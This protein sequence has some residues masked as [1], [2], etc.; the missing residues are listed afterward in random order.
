MAFTALLASLE[1]A[2]VVHSPP[3]EY[4]LYQDENMQVVTISQDNPKV[5]NVLKMLAK[6]S[7][8]VF[9]SSLSQHINDFLG[10]LTAYL[11]FSQSPEKLEPLI[12]AVAQL[13]IRMNEGTSTVRIADMT[14]LFH[15]IQMVTHEWKTLPSHILGWMIDCIMHFCLDSWKDV[16]WDIGTNHK[17]RLIESIVHN[18]IWDRSALVEVVICG[19]LVCQEHRKSI[20]KLVE[21]TRVTE[22]SIT[23]ILAFQKLS[24]VFFN[25]V[26][27]KV[28]DI[29]STLITLFH[30]LQNTPFDFYSDNQYSLRHSF[31]L[32]LCCDFLSTRVL[33][34]LVK[35]LLMLDGSLPTIDDLVLALLEEYDPIIRI[36]QRIFTA[37]LWVQFRT[38]VESLLAMLNET[39]QMH[40]G[41]IRDWHDIVIFPLDAIPKSS[42]T[43][44]GIAINRHISSVSNPVECI[45]NVFIQSF[46][47][48]NQVGIFND[49]IVS[50]ISQSWIAGL[51]VVLEDLERIP[52]TLVTEEEDYICGVR[53]GDS[54]ASILYQLV[55]WWKELIHPPLLNW[56]CI[57][58]PKWNLAKS[59]ACLL[60][61][62]LST[63][64]Q[65][66]VSS[67]SI[68]SLFVETVYAAREWECLLSCMEWEEE[69]CLMI[70]VLRQ[71]LCQMVSVCRLNSVNEHLALLMFEIEKEHNCSTLLMARE[72]VLNKVM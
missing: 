8:E 54:R 63:L 56:S 60:L 53:V 69:I 72:L 70:Q 5:H 11:Q 45:T 52:Q 18:H 38:D 44:L 12:L 40:R 50:L 46:C 43:M 9:L 68:T 64:P 32:L 16:S 34:D 47:G 49:Q 4:V 30:D 27:D 10:D 65:T 6:N 33:L 37:S 28:E 71:L 36:C 26:Q 15:F 35:S 58:L 42:A 66:L 3:R 22:E 55:G 2:T 19:A 13:E 39:H 23:W 61:F 62:H 1:H 59:S 41:V 51:V 17:H 24:L 25:F 20:A 31:G 14:L 29:G 21:L 7:R 48:K 57:F 67:D